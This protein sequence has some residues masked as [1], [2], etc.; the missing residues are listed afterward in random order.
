MPVFLLRYALPALA[1]IGV[2]LGLYRLAKHHGELVEHTRWESRVAK[3][4]KVNRTKEVGVQSAVDDAGKRLTASQAEHTIVETKIV[5]RIVTA[6]A[7]LP[8]CAV[9]PDIMKDRNDLRNSQGLPE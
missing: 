6:T 3:E 5:G 4:D 1:I 8:D 9:T 2:V 7:A